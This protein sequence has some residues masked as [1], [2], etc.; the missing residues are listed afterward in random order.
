ME[1]KDWEKDKEEYNK[2]ISE[3]MSNKQFTHFN[4]MLAEAAFEKIIALTEKQDERKKKRMEDWNELNRKR[5]YEWAGLYVDGFDKP[6][7]D[8]EMQAEYVF[9]VWRPF[10]KVDKHLAAAER[11]FKQ[12]YGRPVEEA[13]AEEIYNLSE[14]LRDVYGKEKTDNDK[15]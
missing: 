7:K 10:R 6:N 15:R 13:D 1:M 9:T 4:K 5:A 8:M 11:I 12:R 2:A 14:L 3:F